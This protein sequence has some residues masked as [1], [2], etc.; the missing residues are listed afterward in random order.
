[1]LI[2]KKFGGWVFWPFVFVRS[3]KQLEDPV[4]LNHERIHMRQ[5]AEL[6][7]IPFFLWYGLEYLI[8][9]IQYKNWYLAYRNI[10]F[11]R[12]AHENEKDLGYL[13]R[14]KSFPFSD[15]I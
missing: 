15:Y 9:L 12:E 1:M 11:E 13:E 6:L 14:R 2:P 10:S 3:K 8:R 5:Q 7:I 4:F